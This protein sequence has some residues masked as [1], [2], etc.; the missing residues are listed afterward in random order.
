[1]FV[2]QVYV[3][4]GILSA[5]TYEYYSRDWHLHTNDTVV[6]DSIIENFNNNVTD[7]SLSFKRV[8]RSDG[9][10]VRGDFL[11]MAMVNK[12]IA[13]HMAILL[14]SVDKMIHA[15]QRKCVVE[16]FYTS[17]WQRRTKYKV[18]IFQEV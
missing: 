3:D 14:E 7:K 17:P 6:E 1:M 9:D 15:H 13:N 8:L 10:L 12:N 2:G 5:L 18:R 11:L 16:D 4:M